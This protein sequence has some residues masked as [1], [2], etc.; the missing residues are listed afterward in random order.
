[1]KRTIVTVIATLAF[2]VIAMHALGLK[3]QPASEALAVAAPAPLAAPLPPACPNI[4]GAQDSLRSAKTEL[5]EAA[6][7]FCG[8]RKDALE[9]VNHALTELRQAENCAKCR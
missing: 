1:M 3:I 4:H 8:H 9:A 5:Q 6:H 7:D 2:A